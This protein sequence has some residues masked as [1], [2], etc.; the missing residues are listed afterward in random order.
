MTSSSL[1][2]IPVTE[3]TSAES[4]NSMLEAAKSTG[5][6]YNL[7]KITTTQGFVSAV[8][9]IATNVKSQ[10]AA[11]NRNAASVIVY[12]ERP[13]TFSVD[14]LDA[15]S[16]ADVD[17]SYIF[18]HG[19]KLYRITIPRGTKV[20]LDASK[21]EGPLFVGRLLGTTQVIE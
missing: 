12:S 20:D 6:S 5:A 19:G 8:E 11:N 10:N 2:A 3:F 16:A 17:F 4:V 14:I 9:K 21:Y 15:V 18:R 1:K 13:M 7:T